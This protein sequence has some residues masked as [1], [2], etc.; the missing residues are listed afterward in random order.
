MVCNH[1]VYQFVINQNK[2]EIAT[3][4]NLISSQVFSQKAAEQSNR[5]FRCW[6]QSFPSCISKHI[7]LHF[8]RNIFTGLFSKDFLSGTDKTQKIFTSVM[9]YHL[10][11]P[12]RYPSSKMKISK[13]LCKVKCTDYEAEGGPLK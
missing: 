13:K 7:L 2:H 11:H 4:N 6:F 5:C 10:H 1:G 8:Y 3:A 12:G 9:A